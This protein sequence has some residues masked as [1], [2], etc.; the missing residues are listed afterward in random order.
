MLECRAGS[1]RNDRDRNR[2][3]ISPDLTGRNQPS[4]TG[5]MI[6]LLTTMDI[7]V[8]SL[9]MMAWNRYFASIMASVWVS[10]CQVHQV[11]SVTKTLHRFF[12]G[13]KSGKVESMG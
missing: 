3:F 12:V 8:D 10:I 5:L 9:K 13:L 2:W 11:V 1:D 4:Y 7:P 6:N